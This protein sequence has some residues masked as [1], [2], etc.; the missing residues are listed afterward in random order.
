M[1][2]GPV[3]LLVVS[4][5]LS[6]GGAQRVVSTILSHLDRS[7]LEPSLYLLRD[8]ITFPLPADVPVTAFRG[9]DHPPIGAMARTRPWIIPQAIAALR[10]HVRDVR[11]DVVLSCID[12][13]NYLTATALE[14]L[15]ARRPRWVARV[16]ANPRAEGRA[17]SAW[18]RWAYR[19]ADAVVVNARA[20]VEGF[21]AA[22]PGSRGRVHCIGNP[23][24]FDAIDRLAAA[25]PIRRR[26][27]SIP[28]I[29]SVG[30]L[31]QEKRP[32]LLVDAFTA[33][34]ARRPAELWL[35]GDGP[36]RADI[37]RTIRDRGLAGAVSCLG[38]L[39][40]P[41]AL[42]AQAD[43]FALSSDHEGL[44][45][46]LIEAQGLGVPAVATDCS[47]GPREIIDDERTGL[48]V[49]TGDAAA[50][51][52][53][54]AALLDDPPRREAMKGAARA[55]VRALFGAAARVADWSRLLIGPLSRAG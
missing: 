10:R 31:N 44:P 19:R 30:R 24:D 15:G 26:D 45:N 11:P 38:F 17:A 46:S 49:P 14:G 21:T 43:L 25:P 16:G 1:R 18:G 20:L 23:T 29:V 53:G 40:N 6:E 8:K 34:H 54:L 42:I 55:R 51:A 4:P 2:S 37:E 7:V 22:Y 41:Y 48:L 3:K 12:Q 28:L 5:S 27:P 35:V 47:F 39:D 33:L 36:M 9:G 32:D 50:L 52:A 13:L